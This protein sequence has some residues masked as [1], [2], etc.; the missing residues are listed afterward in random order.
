MEIEYLKTELFKKEQ[1]R[2]KEI[3]E[4]KR[5][6]ERLESLLGKQIDHNHKAL[7]EI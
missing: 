6:M 2:N 3:Q 7:E 5:T 4:I 1:E